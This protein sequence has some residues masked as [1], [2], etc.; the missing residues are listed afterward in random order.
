MKQK[1]I[2]ENEVFET[3]DLGLANTIYYFNFPIEA[4]NRTEKK[5]IFLFLRD[6][7]LD[8]LIQKYWKHELFVEPVAFLN[9]LKEVK[10]RIYN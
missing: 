3:S 9:C 5:A 7:D 6:R 1:I 4:I 2:K 8:I 10:C